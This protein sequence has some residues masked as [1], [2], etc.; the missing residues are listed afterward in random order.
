MEQE[1]GIVFNVQRYTIHDGPG[2][3]TELFLKGCPLSCKWCGNPESHKPYIQ[4]GIY[5]SKCLGLDKCGSCVKQCGQGAL[6]F[7]DGKLAAI[8]KERCA[9]CVKCA[10]ACPADAIKQWGKKITVAEAMEVIRKDIP[11]YKN[12]GGGVTVSGGEPLL[13]AGFVAG[14]FEECKKEGV[15]TCLETTLC[16]EWDVVARTL[17]VTDLYI[18]DVKHM[19]SAVHKKYTG[20]G[21]ERILENIERLTRAGKPLILRI[22][23]IPGV[24]D[25]EENMEATADFLCGKLEGKILQLQLLEFMRLGEEKYASLCI[26]YPMEGI[27]VDK[28]KFSEKVKG[29]A[30]YFNRRGIP[31]IA[32]TTTK[33]GKKDE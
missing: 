25:A 23:V 31:C 20:I 24:N 9:N 32:G 21:N 12:S 15:H 1:T 2:I 7:R 29:F 6:L 30:A 26:P 13:Q 11:Y 28:D 17:P 8:E 22:P 16:P 4:A 19:D 10:E 3:R 18:S 27:E 14:L 33:E 5:P